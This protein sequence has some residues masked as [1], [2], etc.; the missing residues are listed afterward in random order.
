LD[1]KKEFKELMKQKEKKEQGEY[2]LKNMKRE[3]E[4]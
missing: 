4:V 1:A 2:E 3:A